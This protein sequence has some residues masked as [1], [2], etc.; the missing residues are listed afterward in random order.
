MRVLIVGAAGMLGQRLALQIA[1]SRKIGETPVSAMLL[2]DRVLPA[3]LASAIHSE[4][5]SVEISQPESVAKLIEWRPDVVFHLAAIV[6]SD[7]ESNFDKGYQ[8]NVEATLSILE[9]MKRLELNSRFVFASSLAVFGE[10]FPEVVPDDFHLTPRSSYGSQ[11]AICEFLVSDYSRKGYL[12]G[13]SFRFPTIVVRPG[14]PNAAASG[15]LSSIIREPLKGTKAKLPV[16]LD[17]RA[18]IASPSV[19]INSL[20]HAACLPSGSL[21]KCRSISGRGISVS[22]AE[23][24]QAL[25]DLAGPDVIALIEPCQD[26]EVERIVSS[27]PRAF[28]ADRARELGFPVDKGIHEIIS[29]HIAENPTEP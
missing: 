22:V 13:I 26:S 29:A 20:L 21:S 3:S 16:P 10:P 6:S 11:K 5:R 25:R 14:S 15:F 7:A 8:I 18:W 9:T 24:I 28:S 19:A 27:W 17:T 1:Q 2:V 23:M 12:D 4:S